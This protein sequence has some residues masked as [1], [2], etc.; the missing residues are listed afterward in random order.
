MQ[1]ASA[2]SVSTSAA[3]MP[4]SQLH[5]GILIPIIC[6]G[7]RILLLAVCGHNHC[8]L[9]VMG[10]TSSYPG[11]SC[12]CKDRW[13]ETLSILTAAHDHCRWLLQTV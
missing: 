9:L 10:L 4:C 13:H 8:N 11:K 1:S 7:T 12:S 3:L 6:L 2:K 5:A